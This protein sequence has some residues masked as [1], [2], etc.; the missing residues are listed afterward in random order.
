MNFN[1]LFLA[2]FSFFF[3]SNAQQ[4][5]QQQRQPSFDPRAMMGNMQG[6]AMNMMPQTMPFFNGSN[7]AG[8]RLSI[9]SMGG[10]GSMGGMNPSLLSVLGNNN[11]CLDDNW[12]K[13]GQ[14]CVNSTCKCPAGSSWSGSE[15][16]ASVP[17]ANYGEQC[18]QNHPNAQLCNGDLQ[19]IQ[20]WCDCPFPTVHVGNNYCAPCPPGTIAHERTCQPMV[21][22]VGYGE[23]C[24]EMTGPSATVC[25]GNL[26][27]LHNY[28][29]CP[30]PSVLVGEN[31]CGFAPAA[32]PAPAEQPPTT[33]DV[34]PIAAGTVFV[35]SSLCLVLALVL[36]Q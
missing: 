30:P 22:P 28:C 14:K 32:S 8:N 11:I 29:D 17:P 5:Q 34:P 19:C 23:Q 16:Q 20:G 3:A 27:C 26:M 25:L 2:S 6:N 4:Q 18:A 24:Q 36:L 15:C 31:Q 12:C 33:T 13:G 1:F 10:T 7:P 21:V 35:Q 9:P